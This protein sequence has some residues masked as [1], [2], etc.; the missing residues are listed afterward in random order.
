MYTLALARDPL[1]RVLP[2]FDFS[3]LVRFPA[4]V[5]FLAAPAPI[6]QRG[7]GTRGSSVVF[8]EQNCATVQHHKTDIL[9]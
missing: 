2:R 9:G 8:V 1:A 4:V 6:E 5:V 7:F 3:R